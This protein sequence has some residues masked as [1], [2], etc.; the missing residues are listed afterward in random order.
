MS[1]SRNE[2]TPAD[3]TAANSTSGAG[4][5]LR[6]KPDGDV[7][8]S[9]GKDSEFEDDSGSADGEELDYLI[10]GDPHNEIEDPKERKKEL[11]RLLHLEES[12]ISVFLS[13]LYAKKRYRRLAFAEC[14][15]G[16]IIPDDNPNS[17]EMTILY[18]D[19]LMLR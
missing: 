17:G 3:A 10:Y 14:L 19:A 13:N 16:R 4:S 12:N 9:L 18:K 15:L 7:R 6:S 5:G 8:S 1:S 2:V 11:G